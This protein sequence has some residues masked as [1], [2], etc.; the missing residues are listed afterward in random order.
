[1][2]SEVETAYSHRAAEYV[3]KL[4]STSSAHASDL[5]LITAW[6]AEVDGP[7]LDAGCGPGHWTA[8]LVDQ[9]YDARGLDQVPEFIDHARESFPHV[10]FERGSIDRLPDATGSVG[11]ILAWYSLIHDEP[12]AL[13]AALH[14]FSRVLRPDGLL[15]VGFFTGPAVEPFDHAVVTAYRWP[16]EALA[17]EL[18]AAGFEVMETH[19]RTGRDPKPRPHGAII[20]RKRKAANS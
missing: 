1:M 14:E 9:G 20:A 16:P 5:Q 6:A 17:A 7:I 4:S 8:H 19:T 12:P 2:S 18:Q 3:E 10:A 15:L 13:R 11:G